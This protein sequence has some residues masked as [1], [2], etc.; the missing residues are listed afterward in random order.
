MST[1]ETFTGSLAGL[2]VPW[3]RTTADAFDAAL[4]DVLDPP[5]V[6]APLGIDGLSLADREDVTLAPSPSAL[7]AATTGVTAAGPAIADYGSVVVRTDRAGSEPVSLYVDR[8]VAVVPESA[9]VR[10]MDEALGELG[11]AIRDGLTGA[12]VATGPSATADMGELVYGAHGPRAVH[13][14]LVEDR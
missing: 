1:V 8:H 7:E 3:T 2:D 12:V 9:V 10:S 6:G 4:D 14:V 11:A 5:T 13:V